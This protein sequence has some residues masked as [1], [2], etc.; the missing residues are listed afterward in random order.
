[1][2]GETPTSGRKPV[3]ELPP[4]AVRRIAAGE[5]VARPAAAVKELIENAIDAGADDIRLELRGGGKDLIK[6]TDNGWGMTRDDARLAVARYATSKLGT[7]DD[8]RH[9]ATFGFRGEA[10]A[11]IAAVSRFTLVTNHNEAGPGTKLEVE[12]GD[13]RAIAEA[14]H[15]R[16]TTVTA[17][18]LFYNLP[19]R[20]SFLKSDNYELRLIIETIRSYAVAFPSTR[21]ETVADGRVVHSL[22]PSQSR[23]ERLLEI[24]DRK[25]VEGFLD[26]DVRN[27]MLSLHGFLAEPSQARSYFDVQGVYFN[28]RPVTS[29]VV[30]RAVYDGYGPVIGSQRPDFVL[31]ID[32]DP[33]RLDVNVHPTKQEVRFADDRFLFDFVAEAV[34]KVVRTRQSATV[35][36]DAALFQESFAGEGAETAHG[37]WQLHNG[38]IFAQVTSG[39]VIV[40]QHAAHERILFEELM[41]ASRQVPQQGLLFPIN[42]ELNAPQ[43]EAYEQL[44]ARIA[45]MGIDAKAFSGRTIVV[46]TVPAG[47]YMG[48]DEIRGFFEE[49]PSVS[50]DRAGVEVGLARLLACKGA[51]KF[52]QRLS[53]PEMESLFN[54]LFACQEPYSCPHGRPAIIRITTDELNRRFDRT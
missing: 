31:F 20:R 40:D 39:Y 6:I 28:R 38:Y 45:R 9:V 22:P 1:M 54:R 5:V 10:L 37:F 27:P 14:A 44:A 34:R 4:D 29:R 19:A 36:A 30:L 26:V 33:S 3:R 24:Y 16:G 2:T 7:A 46:E 11:S 15:P 49:L 25:V 12:G 21:F 47:S 51:I 18:M 42:L 35:G 17:R 8:L 52:G 32:T 13:I 41:R 23:R 53:Q 48:K 50:S 43:Y